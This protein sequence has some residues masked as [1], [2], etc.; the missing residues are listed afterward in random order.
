MSKEVIAVDFYNL[1]LT[2]G[3][4]MTVRAKTGDNEH[5]P[6]VLIPKEPIAFT[7]EGFDGYNL[8]S[9]G[10]LAKTVTSGRNDTHNI[11]LVMLR[12]KASGSENSKE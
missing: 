2:G 3:V 6:C 8:Q 12:R 9:T 11:P 1:N 7:T 4:C 5:T 10:A